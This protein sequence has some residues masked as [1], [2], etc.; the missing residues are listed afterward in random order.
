MTNKSK[1]LLAAAEMGYGHLR[2]LYPFQYLPKYRLIIFGQT[3]NSR[4]FEKAL[5]KATRVLYETVSRIRNF[6]IIGWFLYS[7]MNKMLSIPPKN[8]NP[9]KLDKTLSFWLLE[10]LIKMGL[11]RGMINENSEGQR[12]IFTSF[13]APVI[14]LAGQKGVN[15]FC[16]ICDS[17]LSRVWVARDSINSDVRYFAPCK[18]AVE[19]LTNY[20]VREEMIYLTGFPLPNNLVGG[21]GEEL[22][23]RNFNK[24]KILLENPNI[25]SSEFPLRIAYVVG[26]AGAY[27]DIGASIALCLKDEILKG[28]IVLNLVTGTKVKATRQYQVFK[29]KNF[30]NCDSLIINSASNLTDYFNLFSEVVSD[31]HILWTKPSELVFYS[32]LGIP[33]IMTNPLGPQEVANREWVLG[34]GIGIDHRINDNTMKWLYSLLNKGILSRMANNGWEKGI[35]TALYAI[36]EIIEKRTSVS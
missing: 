16:Q 6:P 23:I 15:C 4:P 22:A 31:I 1:V 28:N 24:R 30:S 12:I 29:E 34:S 9:R 21:F 5:W 20:G 7:S 3:D 19:R 14:A 25:L 11:C 33:L 8:S 35:R 13:Y 32:A 2:A 36:P 17:D 10:L 18:K 27:T 26:G